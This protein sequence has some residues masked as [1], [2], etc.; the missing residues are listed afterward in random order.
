MTGL[1][2]KILGFA[3]L[4]DAV[5]IRVDLKMLAIREIMAFEILSKDTKWHIKGEHFKA[6]LIL[7]LFFWK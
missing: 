2:I 4:L 7:I 1:G 5:F 6:E 3:E